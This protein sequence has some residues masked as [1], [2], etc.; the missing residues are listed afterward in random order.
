VDNYAVPLGIALEASASQIANV[1]A[2]PNLIASLAF[3][4][5]G[6]LKQWI[7]SR[8]K[9]LVSAVGLQIGCL[10]GLALMPYFP[11]PSRIAALMSLLVALAV[12]G[13]LATPMWGSLMCEYLPPARRSS[14]FG[15]RN[16]FVGG[17]A[18]LS[19]VAAG[20]LLQLSGHR[21]LL[22]FLVIF[23]LAA[24]ARTCSW[25]YLKAMYEPREHPA[26]APDPSC[27][28]GA[29]K[30][31][32][33]F[34]LYYGVMSFGISLFGPL[35]PIYL[36]RELGMSYATYTAMVLVSQL[37]MY[38][39]MGRWGRSADRAGNMKV[40]QVTA[41]CLPLTA[42]LWMF[43]THTFYMIGVQLL[44]GVIWAGYNLC[45]MNFVFDSV[46]GKMRLHASAWFNTVN[47]VA[48]FVGATF[49][50]QLLAVLPPI[51]GRSFY[52]LMLLSALARFI[53]GWFLF[54][55]L[56]E[57]RRVATTNDRELVFGVI[58]LKR[59]DA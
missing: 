48:V 37:T 20:L 15:W 28:Q 25:H 51:A 40:I 14:Y 23:L 41:R 38:W 19:S 32:R 52:S 36:L 21:V 39:M 3:L 7:G 53:P 27:F 10:L 9:I 59:T 4:Q 29:D 31:F 30:N 44:S 33:R 26:P 46:P 55:R 34:I 22:G 6:P 54:P 11:G 2:L 43:S 58:G 50:G 8:K 57:V 47:G 16:R 1:A 17:A 45:T 24:A 5:A 56:R 13:G 42:L 18:T 35:F 49:G 12:L